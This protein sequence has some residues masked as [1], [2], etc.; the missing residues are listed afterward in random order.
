MRVRA[1]RTSKTLP[2]VL[3]GLRTIA[4]GEVV[5]ETA[6][7]IAP[8]ME[9]A[10]VKS[11]RPH[12]RTGAAEGRAKWKAVGSTIVGENVAYAKFIPKYVFA[13]RLPNNWFVRIKA[14]LRRKTR[15]ALRGIS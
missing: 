11:L 5:G 15:E 13:K 8:L 3:A 14:L 6:A 4:F 12:R 9:K 10:A 7:E 1:K 2:K